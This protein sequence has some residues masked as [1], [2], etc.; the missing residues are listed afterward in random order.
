[1]LMKIIEELGPWTWWIIG[2]LFLILE[3]IVPGVFF[4]WIG[5]A[6]LVLGTAALL[7]PMAWQVQIIGFAVLAVAFALLGRRINNR[8]GRAPENQTLNQRG[9][10]YIGQNYV[11]DADLDNGQGRVKIGD[12]FWLVRGPAGLSAGSTVRVV[13]AEGTVLIVEAA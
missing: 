4:L 13:E 8:F 9:K 5:F 1:M 10:Q 12:T 11:L 2:F 6:A 3:I 7:V